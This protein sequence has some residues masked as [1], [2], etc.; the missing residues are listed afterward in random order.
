MRTL[1]EIAEIV[2]EAVANDHVMKLV[3]DWELI[4]GSDVCYTDDEDGHELTKEEISQYLSGD[5][6]NDVSKGYVD[7]YQFFIIES[8]GA[9]YLMRHTDEIVYYSEKLE[10]YVWGIDD[11]GTPWEAVKRPFREE[12]GPGLREYWESRGCTFAI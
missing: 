4:N 7:I 10:M 8:T 2:G 11:F 3:D 1:K 6:P 9:D 12:S 5:Y